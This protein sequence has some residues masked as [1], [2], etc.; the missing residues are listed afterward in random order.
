MDWEVFLKGSAIIENQN[1]T[2][3][4]EDSLIS[5]HEHKHS[6]TIEPAASVLGFVQTGRKLAFTHPAWL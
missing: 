5:F 2:I 1:A 6:L 3:A 4:S